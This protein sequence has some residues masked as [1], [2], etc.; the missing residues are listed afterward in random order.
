MRKFIKSI[1]HLI[2]NT[3]NVTLK[4]PS[5]WPCIG[6]TNKFN[7]EDTVLESLFGFTKLHITK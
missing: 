5:P 7:V 2:I 6:G 4:V 1:W 3:S